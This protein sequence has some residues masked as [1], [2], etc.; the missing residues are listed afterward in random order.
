ML[1]QCKE[2][3]DRRAIDYVSIRGCSI[4]SRP[5]RLALAHVSDRLKVLPQYLLPQQALTRFAGTVASTEAGRSAI[6][7]ECISLNE[8]RRKCHDDPTPFHAFAAVRPGGS[9]P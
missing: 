8:E 4:E 5:L 6:L 2:C 9:Q 1:M 7:N 3:V